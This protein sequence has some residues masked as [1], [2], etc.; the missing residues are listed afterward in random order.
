[1]DDREQKIRERAH[2]IWE[3]AGRP[4]GRHDDHWDQ[5]RREVDGEDEQQAPTEPVGAGT[6]LQPGG[7]T[8]GN[9]P[10]A[11]MGSI[12]TGGGSTAGAATGSRKRKA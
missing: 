3:Q 1:M 4:D 8:P 12:G 9:S 6:P 2:A 7:T 10:A 11:G 5:A